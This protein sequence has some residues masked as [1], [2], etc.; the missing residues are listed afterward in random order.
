MQEEIWQLKL[1]P[2]DDQIKQLAQDQDSLENFPEFIIDRLLKLN[3]RNLYF[4]FNE[5]WEA[6]KNTSTQIKI[7]EI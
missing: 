4:K 1:L 2:W 6:L 5:V 3:N 7:E